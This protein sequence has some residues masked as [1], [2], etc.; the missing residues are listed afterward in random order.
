[1][2]SLEIPK[3]M[4]LERRDKAKIDP[5]ITIVEVPVRLFGAAVFD[6]PPVIFRLISRAARRSLLHQ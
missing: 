6:L 1:M 2:A 5:I 3:E 4:D